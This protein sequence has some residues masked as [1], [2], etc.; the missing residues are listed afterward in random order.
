LTVDD[1]DEGI[2]TP[3]QSKK[4]SVGFGDHIVK[5]VVEGTP[6]LMWRKLVQVKNTEQVAAMIGLKALHV[7]YDDAVRQVQ[8]QK[9]NAGHAQRQGDRPSIA[10]PGSSTAET[11]RQPQAEIEL[12]DTLNAKSV[13][14]PL[15]FGVRVDLVRIIPEVFVPVTVRVWNR[16]LT[17]VNHGDTK[18]AT[19]NLFI[20]I[21]SIPSNTVEA[22]YFRTLDIDSPIQPSALDLKKSTVCW[23]RF[24]SKPGAYKFEIAMLDVNGGRKGARS[25]EIVIEGFPQGKLAASSL[26]VADKME[27]IPKGSDQVDFAIGETFVRPMVPSGDDKPPTFIRDQKLNFWVQ[28]YNLALEG[29]ARTPS[30]TVEYDIVE[31]SSNKSLLHNVETINRMDADGGQITLSRSVPLGTVQPGTYKLEIR[32]NDNIS[33]QTVDPSAIFAVE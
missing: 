3:A 31:I 29:K 23:N 9:E 28:I 4:I 10:K 2:L 14:N 27:R 26:I 16:D 25:K 8:Q 13:V 7:Q 20:R 24:W 21:S 11:P 15:P 32:V 19:I 17:F 22:K 1:Q 30:T 18:R 6:D 5:C 12:E 33:E